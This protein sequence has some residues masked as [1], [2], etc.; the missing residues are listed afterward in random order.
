M[1]TTLKMND[2]TVADIAP[3][4]EGRATY[5]DAANPALLLR[6][7]AAG[8]KTWYVIRSVAGVSRRVKL[9]TWPASSV[10]DARKLATSTVAKINDG[11]DPLANRRAQR[12]RAR[13]K[14]YTVGDGLADYIGDAEKGVRLARGGKRVKASTVADYRRREPLLEHLKRK[15]MADLSLPDLD[16]IKRGNKASVAAHAIKLLRG[17]CN[18]AAERGVIPASLFAGRKG[19]AATL[20]PRRTFIHA[21]DLGRFLNAL[22]ALQEDEAATATEKIGG[23]ALLLMAIYGL[24][25][26]EALTLPVADVDLKAGEFRVRETKNSDPL[27]LPVTPLARPV[28][29]RRLDFAR[30][31]GSACAFPTVATKRSAG[32]NLTDPQPAIDKIEKATELA[33]TCHDLRRTFSSVAN[34]RLSH[35]DIKAVVNHRAKRFDDVTLNYIQ[36]TADDLRGPLKALHAELAKLKA[37]AAKKRGDSR[38]ATGRKAAGQGDGSAKRSKRGSGPGN[39]A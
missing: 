13:A 16:R 20:P 27:T 3:P 7:T 33:F 32:G 6:V 1:P 25:K 9:G 37:A 26:N 2:R 29:A 21:R 35:A 15:P 8:A 14:A 36:V 23:D 28:L 18:Y 24:R 12:E 19:D 31:L 10:A 39:A 4:A 22:D 34:R 38:P 17:A 11:V 5:R 30:L